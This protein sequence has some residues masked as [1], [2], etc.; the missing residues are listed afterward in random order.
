MDSMPGV[1]RQYLPMLPLLLANL[2]GI[3][4]V[5]VYWS[6]CPQASLLALLAMSMFVVMVLAHQYIW[7]WLADAV[8]SGES[9]YL[10]ASLLTNMVY[11]GG[12]VMMIIAVIGWRS[13]P[14]GGM[15]MAQYPPGAYPPG[16]YPPP[17]PHAQQ[18]G[19][20]GPPAY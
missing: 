18:Y 6:R 7:R 10:I 2:V 17:P 5:I 20:Q 3:I 13:Q 8:E 1:V 9:G 15:P 19:Q 12:T 4:L 14:A 11:A 16:A